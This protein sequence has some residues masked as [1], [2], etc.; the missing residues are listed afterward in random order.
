MNQMDTISILKNHDLRITA[1]RQAV[2]EAF[3]TN[4]GAL[5]TPQLEND[6]AQFDRVTLYRTLH[7]FTEKGILHIIPDDSGA[8][9][10]GICFE[11]CAPGDHQHN[12]VHFKC[13]DCGT[14]SCLN[15][16]HVPAFKIPGFVVKEINMIL[17]GTCSQCN[18]V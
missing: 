8:A 16:H 13:E 3:L 18:A 12:H 17:R 5:S 7:S 14:I 15:N 10:Y 4:D 1:C 9:Q 2:L 6:L 11:T